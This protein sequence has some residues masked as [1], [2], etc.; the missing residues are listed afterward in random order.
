VKEAWK[1][2]CSSLGE[3][4]WKK[5]ESYACSSLADY[6][7]K[8]EA[9]CQR[10]RE[11]SYGFKIVEWFEPIFKAVELFTPAAAVA[12][13]AYPNPGSLVLGGIVGVL[14]TT[15][16]LLSYQKLTVQMLAKMGRKARKLLEYEKDVYKDDYPVQ[17]ALVQVYGDIIV[18]CQKAFRFLTENGQ[19]RA[20]VKGL[21]LILIRDYE[22]QLGKEVQDFEDN[23][24]YLEEKACLC[25]KRRLKELRESQEAHHK[26]IGQL[27]ADNQEYFQRHDSLLVNLLKREQDLRERSCFYQVSRDSR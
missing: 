27:V 13:Q 17:R 21:G 19:V 18:F 10:H 7:E 23:I 26:E 4:E 15:N 25:D 12:I 14:Q 5:F 24:E 1:S 20:K 16:R 3:E 9:A 11:E 2:R 6:L 22:S 8:L